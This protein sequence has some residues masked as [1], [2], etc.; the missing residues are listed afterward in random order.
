MNKFVPFALFPLFPSVEHLF[1]VHNAYAAIET[2]EEIDV[3]QR[4]QLLVPVQLVHADHFETDKFALHP[5]LTGLWRHRVQLGDGGDVPSDDG[6][7]RVQPLLPRC[8]ED[9]VFGP[10]GIVLNV[11]QQTCARLDQLLATRA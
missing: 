5:L 3:G 9:S 7:E 8:R 10:P 4:C 6:D 2:L 11:P 1:L